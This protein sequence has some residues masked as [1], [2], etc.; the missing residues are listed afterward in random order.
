MSTVC[1]GMCTSKIAC[2]G[3]HMLVLAKHRSEGVHELCLEEDDVT[4]D[5][6]G[7]PYTEL[8]GESSRPSLSRSLSARVRRRERVRIPAG[9]PSLTAS[10]G[11]LSSSHAV[12]ITCFSIGILMTWSFYRDYSCRM[13]G[14][15]LLEQC[16]HFAWKHIIH[17]HVGGLQ[18]KRCDF[19]MRS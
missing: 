1:Y 12:I 5:F 18:I 9:G 16:V 10:G 6:L 15:Q 14:W 2:G 4:E 3:C 17:M 19:Q 11:G 13:G 8:Q 7:T